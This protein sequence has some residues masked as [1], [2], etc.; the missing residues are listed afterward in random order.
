M[1]QFNLLPEVKISFIRTQRLKRV[2]MVSALSVIAGSVGLLII[3][4]SLAAVQKQHISNLNKDIKSLSEELKNSP[5]L[6]R[7]L[8]IQHQLDA[9]P[10]LYSGRP[11]ADRI[12]A[13]IDQTTPVGVNL[14]GLEA[15][16]SL[17]TME[18]SGVSARLELVNSY[19]DTLKYTTFEKK[20]DDGISSQPV[21]A[22]S[23]VVLKEFAR[24]NQEAT[25]TISFKL[26]PSIFDVNQTIALIVPSLVTTRAQVPGSDLFNGTTNQGGN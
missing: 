12:P 25:F 20:S 17:S 24:D 2:V 8:S 23:E 22:F 6:T 9:L 15:D 11:S 3:M 13:Y 19:V 4:F 16:F 5:D 14:N 21:N 26:D 18:I 7:I 1:I 10:A